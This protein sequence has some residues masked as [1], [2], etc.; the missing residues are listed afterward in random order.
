MG[1]RSAYPRHDRDFYRT[2]AAAVIPLIPHLSAQT[3]DEPC[4]G[5]GELI[6]HLKRHGF[7][8]LRASD[9]APQQI[10]IEM[11]A[12]ALTDCAAEQFITNP[13]LSRDILHSL[14][15]RLSD[16]APTWLLLDADWAHTKQAAPYRTRCAKIVSVGRVKWIEGS[17]YSGKDNHAWYLFERG[18]TST[19][20]VWRD[21]KETRF[22]R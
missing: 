14:I 10:G 8:C 9:I 22:P 11:D 6:R 2:P 16:I 15:E 17:K 19:T 7:S 1:K 20:F 13:P 12:L 18:A 3:F 21:Q 4:C 5:D